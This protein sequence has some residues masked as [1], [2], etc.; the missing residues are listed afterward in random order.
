MPSNHDNAIHIP[1]LFLLLPRIPPPVYTIQTICWDLILILP[2]PSSPGKGLVMRYNTAITI[3]YHNASPTQVVLLPTDL[4][5]YYYVAGAA[6]RSESI[7]RGCMDF[8]LLSPLFSTILFIVFSSWN[9]NFRISE[10]EKIRPICMV[11]PTC[12]NSQHVK[13]H[14]VRP[15]IHYVKISSAKIKH[16]IL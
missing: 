15:Y 13:N 7:D 2:H 14:V 11:L 8:L 1:E 10:M 5:R 16:C 4:S 9:H 12:S 3:A 6:C